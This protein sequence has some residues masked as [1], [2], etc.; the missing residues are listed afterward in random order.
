MRR[1]PACYWESID[2]LGSQKFF[3]MGVTG[4]WPVLKGAGFV[5]A[6]SSAGDGGLGEAVQTLRRKVLSVDL[7]IWIVQAVSQPALS[8]AGF[9]DRAAVAKVC[10]ER[11]ARSHSHLEVPVHLLSSLSPCSRCTNLLRM[12]VTPVGVLE[13]N[14][15]REKLDTLAK[16]TG[17]TR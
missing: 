7:S 12:G 11:C 2:G 3:A 17:F 10:F 16:R 14:P 1:S 8:D 13:G 9:S 15:P 5:T 6:F 4:L